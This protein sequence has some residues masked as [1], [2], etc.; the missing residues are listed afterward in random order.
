MS[1]L[2]WLAAF[3]A[4]SALFLA[5]AARGEEETLPPEEELK[6]IKW[7]TNEDYDYVGDPN[8]RKGGMIRSF[9]TS[10][11]P[12]LRTEGPQSNLITLS[13]IHG[14]IY[15]S[16]LSTHPTTLE[17]MP[18]LASHWAISDD[19]MTFWFK[20]DPDANIAYLLGLREKP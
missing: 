4:V 14:Y 5:P 19:K 20:M 1:R 11:P 2:A 13:M 17:F 8:A 10:Y 3:L 7:Q 18:N 9:W 6:T 16:L 15:E 12:T